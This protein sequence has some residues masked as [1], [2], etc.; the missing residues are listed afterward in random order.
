MET[1][2]APIKE[3]QIQAPDHK[4][5]DFTKNMRAIKFLGPRGKFKD[6]D[7]FLLVFY[8]EGTGRDEIDFECWAKNP[9]GQFRSDRSKFIAGLDL[10][11]L[12]EGKDHPPSPQLDQ[13]RYYDKIAGRGN[14]KVPIIAFGTGPTSRYVLYRLKGASTK[15][16]FERLKKAAGLKS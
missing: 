13:L 12:P 15:E 2:V 8:N 5:K 6:L 10:I 7:T 9:E 11:E 4:V 1:E 14:K 16:S 3:N